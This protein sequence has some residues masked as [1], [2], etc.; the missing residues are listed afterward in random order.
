[1]GR[2]SGAYSPPDP[3]FDLTLMSS[4]ISLAYTISL[5]GTMM[6]TKDGDK[7]YYWRALR[8]SRSFPTSA[9]RIRTSPARAL[10]KSFR[11]LCDKV[12]K[13]RS[14]RLLIGKSESLRWV[15][16]ESVGAFGGHCSGW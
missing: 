5:A 4:A 1:M 16:V 10:L 11:Y 7:A 3:C 14:A 2:H 8:S 12:I 6:I 9:S 15:A 13:T